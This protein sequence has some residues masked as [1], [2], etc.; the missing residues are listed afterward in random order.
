MHEHVA[1]RILFVSGSLRGAS[2]NAAALRTARRVAPAG[3]ETVVYEGL[4]SLPAFNPDLEEDPP[5]A[6]VE[7]RRRIHEASGLLFCVP[8]YA[9][10]LPGALKNLLDWTIG[11]QAPGSLYEKPV[12]WLN[13]SPRGARGAHAELRTVLGYAHAAIVEAACLEAPV[14]AALVGADG[15]VDDPSLRR[16]IARALEALVA[17]AG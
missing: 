4:G 14:T 12:A 16:G 9:G 13:V 11:D 7:L 2:T 1:R 17:A 5:P 8:E 6:V 15:E 10:A 3:V